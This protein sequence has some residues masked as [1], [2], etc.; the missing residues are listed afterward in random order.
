MTVLLLVTVCCVTGGTEVD[1]II[2]GDCCYITGGTEYREVLI[3]ETETSSDYMVQEDL[4]SMTEL[5]ACYWMKG[6]Y[7]NRMGHPFSIFTDG[8]YI[9]V[10]L[11]AF[12]IIIGADE[13][14]DLASHYLRCHA[15]CL[16]SLG[17]LRYLRCFRYCVN[18]NTRRRTYKLFYIVL[19]SISHGSL[20]GQR[21]SCNS[22]II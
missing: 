5:T 4:P 18:G 2:A 9:N 12:Y 14:S 8:N 17:Y 20:T 1:C 21:Y 22:L 15:K 16:Q 11:Q 13:F 7:S 3:Y 19:S 6:K 10:G